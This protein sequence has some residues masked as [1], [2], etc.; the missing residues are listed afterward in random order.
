ME[1]QDSKPRDF[2]DLGMPKDKLEGYLA[3]NQ[4][5]TGPG[6]AAGDGTSQAE[7]DKW[8]TA[9]KAK[10]VNQIIFDLRKCDHFEGNEIFTEVSFTVSR[11]LAT[12][13]WQAAC[14]WRSVWGAMFRKARAK[15]CQ[16]LEKRNAI[17]V[18]VVAEKAAFEADLKSKLHQIRKK[19]S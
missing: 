11:Q 15:A 8:W 12:V 19:V 4:S 2:K 3:M 6:P 10:M 9:E 5:F 16:D 7:V 17:P 1:N 14:G 18:H 13:N